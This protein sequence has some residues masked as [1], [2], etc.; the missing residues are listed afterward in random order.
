TQTR[1]GKFRPWIFWSAIPLGLASY[2]VFAGP[3][4]GPTGKVIYAAVTL[5]LMI[6][7]YGANNIP[8]S[9]LGGVISDDPDERVGVASWRM[10]F[11]M[12][13]AF[14]VLAFSLDMVHALGGGDRTQGF[15]LTAAIWGSLAVGCSIAA[16]FLT[17]ERIGTSAG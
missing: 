14:C 6:I 8:Y 1:W 12:A 15:R 11:A 2:L 4:F 16:F 9:A 10:I 7:A 5:H 3:Q 17:R 13:A